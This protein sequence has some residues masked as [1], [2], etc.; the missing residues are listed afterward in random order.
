MISALTGLAYWQAENSKEA[1]AYY[2]KA[3]YHLYEEKP[4]LLDVLSRSNLLNFLALA[5]QDIGQLEDADHYAAMA[6]AGAKK[7][8]LGRNEERYKAKG[9]CGRGLACFLD[10][11][12]DFSVI[13]EGRNPYG[14][15]PLR[16][17]ELALS[18]Q[19]EN[20]IRR[21]EFTQAD[22][23]IKKQ[24]Q[25]FYEHD[26]DLKHGQ[27]GYLNT[28]NKEALISYKAGKYKEAAASFLKAAQK[29]R[30]F[31]NM[32]SYRIN[33]ANYFNS[34]LSYL[35]YASPEIEEALWQIENALEEWE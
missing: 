34:L 10:F 23:L 17:Y 35:E 22:T 14:F 30:D 20:M 7:A 8:N 6:A 21:D 31:S 4:E 33:Y 16:Q 18:I 25:V 9:Y 5:Y 2:R 24:R 15:A 12:E 11:G 29:A 28:L 19:L 26:L 3:D 13:G 27:T 1:I 32:E